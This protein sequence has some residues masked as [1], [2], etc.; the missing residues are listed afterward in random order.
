MLGWVT[1]NPGPSGNNLML[2]SSEL[3]GAEGSRLTNRLES[4]GMTTPLG[5]RTNSV[6]RHHLHTVVGCK[7]FFVGLPILGKTCHHWHSPS[8]IGGVGRKVKLSITT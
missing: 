2:T 8:W 4:A 6:W 1:A 5:L 7:A 3:L